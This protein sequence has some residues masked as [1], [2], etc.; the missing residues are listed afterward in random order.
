MTP[1]VT[2]HIDRL[3]LQG[4]AERD[5]AQVVQAFRAELARLLGQSGAPPRGASIDRLDAGVIR[6][7]PG[8][9]P[10]WHGAQA[11][12]QIHAA[13]LQPRGSGR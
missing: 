8:R 4:F 11:A 2:L 13:L 12:R 6:L 5:G 10:Q 9:D 7:Q 1:P 3:V